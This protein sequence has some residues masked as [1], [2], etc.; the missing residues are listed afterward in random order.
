MVKADDKKEINIPDENLRKVLLENYDID[1]D[2][3]ITENDLLNIDTFEASNCNIV[4]LEG[5]EYAKNMSVINASNNRISDL[6]PLR[7]L[8]KLTTA[9]LYSNK[10]TNIEPLKYVGYGYLSNNYIEDITPL[11]DGDRYMNIDL[12]GNYIDVSEGTENRKMLEK[13]E[14]TKWYIRFFETS[15]KYKTSSERED[16]LQIKESLKQRLIQQG[17]DKNGDG[18]IT[19]G[20]MND[21]NCGNTSR[22]GSMFK[23]C[24]IDLSNLG[25]TDSDIECL[26]YLNCITE[27]DLSNNKLTDVSA[28]KYMGSLTTLNLAN[29]NINLSTLKE[30]DSVVNFDLSN[31]NIKD[32]SELGNLAYREA[33]IGWFAGGGDGRNV[34]LNLSHNNIKDI[35][36][37]NKIEFLYNI[38]LSYNQIKDISSLANYKFM[39]E[40]YIE[41]DPYLGDF[42]IDFSNNYI[43][44]NSVIVNEIIEKFKKYKG[45]II[46]QNQL[47][48]SEEPVVVGDLDGDGEISLYDAFSILRNAILDDP[49]MSLEEIEVM[50]F[51]GDGK[52]TLYD[53]FMILREAILAG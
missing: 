18:N 28:L 29:N 50:D 27:L 42:T 35:E 39:E 32:A 14:E 11:A 36:F 46:V 37:L 23:Q 4:N 8:N 45:I 5:L 12:C 13:D 40:E 53:A 26:K 10:I 51:D 44:E 15:Q 17:I 3:K 22:E 24:K 38:N 43:D 47:K 21:F 1:N 25:L 6:E 52:V 31:N 49:D 41:E 33:C 9:F 30:L 7:N 2:K 19:K 20:E 16:I 48:P 34:T